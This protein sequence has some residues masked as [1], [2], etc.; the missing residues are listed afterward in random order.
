MSGE[1]AIRLRGVVKRYGQITA[2][3]GLDLNVPVG[4]IKSRLHTAVQKLY[5]YW[6]K[7]HST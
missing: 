2:V 1:L 6:T 4:T 7:T 5:D 3:A